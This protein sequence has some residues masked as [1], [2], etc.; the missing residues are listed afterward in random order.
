MKSR[1]LMVE[2]CRFADLEDS[3][4]GKPN[5]SF[6]PPLHHIVL[7]WSI[8]YLDLKRARGNGSGEDDEDIFQ[9]QAF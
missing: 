1:W 7:N 4:G 5:A 6:L 3:F 2:S 8:R 9:F